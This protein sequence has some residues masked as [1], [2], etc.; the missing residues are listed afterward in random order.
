MQQEMLLQVGH[1]SRQRQGGA[2]Q[3]PFERAGF[4]VQVGGLRGVTKVGHQ[5]G[6][7]GKWDG[8]GHGLLEDMG[9]SSSGREPDKPEGAFGKRFLLIAIHK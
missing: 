2:R 8:S 5:V 1:P 9:D 4:S 7:V 3:G 6:R